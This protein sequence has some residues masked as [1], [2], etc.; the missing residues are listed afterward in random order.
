[1]SSARRLPIPAPVL[2]SAVFLILLLIGTFVTLAFD[3]TATHVEIAL[4]GPSAQHWLGADSLGRDLSLRILGGARVS[5][6]MGLACSLLSALIGI[7]LGTL[8][9]ARGGWLD[10]FVMRFAEVLSALPQLITIGLLVIFLLQVDPFKSP[11]SSFV[12]LILAISLGSWTLMAR[13][14][15]HLVAR[16]KSLPY[17]ESA[18]AIGASGL[19]IAFRHWLPNLAPSLL[20]LIGLQLPNFLLFES[21]LSF[22]GVG[23]QPPTPSWGLLLQEGWRSMTVSPHLLLLPAGLL[24]VTVLSLNLIFEALRKR[25]LRRNFSVDLHH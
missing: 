12:A 16:E 17:S 25:L 8:A 21:F 10:N 9:G 2:S 11:T 22:L 4:Q 6:M 14:V 24:F 23:L 1:M 20:V 5:L 13:T 7:V 3:S 18:V 15:R 19:R